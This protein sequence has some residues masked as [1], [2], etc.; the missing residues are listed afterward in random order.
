MPHKRNEQ[1]IPIDPLAST[2]EPYVHLI[3][4]NIDRISRD[5]FRRGSVERRRAIRGLIVFGVA[6]VLVALVTVVGLLIASPH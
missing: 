6:V 5:T 1:G 3:A 4:P 2:Q